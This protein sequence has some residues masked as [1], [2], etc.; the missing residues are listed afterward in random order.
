M[1]AYG[2][3]QIIMGDLN[4]RT[5]TEA[6]FIHEEHDAHSPMQDICHYEPDVPLQ[7]SNA[8]LNPTDE[9]GKFILSMCKN[10]Q[11]RILNGRTAGDRWGVPT[12]YPLHRKE[13]PSVIDYGICSARLLPKLN[14]FYVLP[15]TILSDHCC[16]SLSL[17]TKYHVDTQDPNTD[18]ANT[19]EQTTY[20]KFQ[21]EFLP[22]FQ[23]NLSEDN[24]FD[25]LRTAIDNISRRTPTQSDI[26]QLVEGFHKPVMENAAKSFPSKKIQS[27]NKSL[28]K[29]HKPAKWYNDNCTKA[30]NKLKRA[31]RQ[32]NKNPYDRHCQELFI[33]ARKVYKRTC[34]EAE[35]QSRQRL[36]EKLLEINDPKEFWNMVN[37]M[38]G[39][40]RE[41]VDPSDTIPPQDWEEHFQ[42]LLNTKEI[43]DQNIPKTPNN[44]SPVMDRKIKMEELETVLAKSK[45]GKARGPDG[46]LMEYF[47]YAPENVRKTLVGLMNIIFP[48][49]FTPRR[50]QLTSSK[51]YTKVGQHLT[52]EITEA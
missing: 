1:A 44:P 5:S 27:K 6:A 10:L 45:F 51:P 12:R 43:Q 28:A 20:P 7:R 41:T 42:N 29:I 13:K 4:G 18:L 46:T 38:K 33:A 36:L 9:H 52:L 37:D 48:V 23:Q 11:V 17:S 24:R 34:K 47:K 3:H 14:S 49:P 25:T 19:K 21:W 40:G 8:D 2:D 39:W 50:G 31:S 22:L 35:S 32:L 16:I 15:H 30:K 26:D